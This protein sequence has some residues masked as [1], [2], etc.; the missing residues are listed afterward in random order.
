MKPVE[1]LET[2]SAVDN[3]NSMATLSIFLGSA[4]QR[5]QERVDKQE[6]TRKKRGI[7]ELL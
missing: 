1:E 2:V 5:V 7:E 3:K 4:I 6:Y